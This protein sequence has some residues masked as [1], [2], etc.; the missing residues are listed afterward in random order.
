M[1][2]TV[3]VRQAARDVARGRFR[4]AT[5]KDRNATSCLGVLEGETHSR[6]SPGFAIL[7]TLSLC[8][9]NLPSIVSEAFG[10]CG[11]VLHKCGPGNI[12]LTRIVHRCPL[13]QL[14]QL[15]YAQKSLEDD[16]LHSTT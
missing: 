15:Y 1:A 4:V 14:V 9:S 3:F 16:C 5:L 2:L 12:I 8:H 13:N 11:F 7:S 10:S 6:P